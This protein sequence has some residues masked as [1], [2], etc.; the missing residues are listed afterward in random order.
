MPQNSNYIPPPE[1]KKTSIRTMH[2]DIQ[3]TPINPLPSKTIET[4]LVEE[5]IS[6]PKTEPT[7]LAPES[8][9]QQIEP[10]TFEASYESSISV[11]PNENQPPLPTWAQEKLEQETIEQPIVKKSII[12]TL[13]I[14]A[15]IMSFILIGYFLATKLIFQSST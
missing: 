5:K 12:F 4:D 13:V 7:L 3:N 10:K 6:L 15:T 14:I 11:E 8:S 9:P 1:K 2:S